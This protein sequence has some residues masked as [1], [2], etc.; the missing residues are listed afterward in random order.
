MT[1]NVEVTEGNFAGSY[2]SNAGKN[3]P[4]TLSSV[5]LKNYSVGQYESV[6]KISFPDA[7]TYWIVLE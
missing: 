3:R 4:D 5:G 2:D 6:F 7:E 1:H